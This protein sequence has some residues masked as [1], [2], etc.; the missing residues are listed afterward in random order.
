[1]RRLRNILRNR[2]VG[3][4][5]AVLP[6]SLSPCRLMHSATFPAEVGP[7]WYM[8]SITLHEQTTVFMLP[9]TIC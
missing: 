7:M 3:G 1:M 6:G 4:V 5:M 9:G 2:C 8:L